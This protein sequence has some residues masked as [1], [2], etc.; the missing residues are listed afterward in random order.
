MGADD[1][2]PAHIEAS[3]FSK[4]FSLVG[5]FIAVSAFSVLIRFVLVAVNKWHGYEYSIFGLVWGCCARLLQ[6]TVK[7]GIKHSLAALQLTTQKR[8]E[9][10]EQLAMLRITQWFIHAELV[11]SAVLLI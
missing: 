4:A 2:E 3:L 11:F 7:A 1:S 6:L 5:A 10:G 8:K 9:L